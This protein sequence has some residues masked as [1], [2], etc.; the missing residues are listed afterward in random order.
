MSDS[1]WESYSAEESA[2]AAP[3]AT[4]ELDVGPLQA[5]LA[6]V[7]E[8]ADI[9]AWQGDNATSWADWH[10]AGADE[11]AQDAVEELE[12]AAEAYAGGYDAAGDAAIARA[13][14]NADLAANRDASADDYYGTAASEYESAADGYGTAADTLADPSAYET[15]S[16]DTAAVDTTSYDTTSYDT[17]SYDT[18]A[19]DTT[20]YDTAA[21]DTS[22]DTTTE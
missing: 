21:V 7:V 2:A 1:T 5:D 17:S 18:A 15:T 12:Y 14:Y 19:V 11:A 6:P 16:Y 22:Y 8:A 9:D 20:S 3:E 4:T 13:E 10:Q